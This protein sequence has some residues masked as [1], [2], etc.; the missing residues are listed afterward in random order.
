MPQTSTLE[1]KRAHRKP[2]IGQTKR[3]FLDFCIDGSSLYDGLTDRGFD[4]I[5][6][7]GWGDVQ[8]QQVAIDRLLCQAPADFPGEKISLYICAECGDLACG[9]ISLIIQEEEGF[10]VWKDFGFQ[11]KPVF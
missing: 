3:G 10:V 11:C 8:G 2:G 9:A 1:L 7:V 6:C 5:S 4:D